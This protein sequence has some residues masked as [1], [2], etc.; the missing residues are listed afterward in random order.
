MVDGRDIDK[1]DTTDARENEPGDTAAPAFTHQSTI[2]GRIIASLLCRHVKGPFK[3]KAL[4]RCLAKFFTASVLEKPDQSVADTGN[5]KGKSG[6]GNG[7]SGEPGSLPGC[8][9]DAAGQ[10][11]LPA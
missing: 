6:Y 4:K 1:L 7:V 9:D 2:P 11:M 10:K 8:T 5:T 3:S